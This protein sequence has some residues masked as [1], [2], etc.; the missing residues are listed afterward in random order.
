[1][2]LKNFDGDQKSTYRQGKSFMPSE[3]FTMLIC[4]PRGCGKTN[5][6]FN[7]LLTPLVIYDV[8]YVYAKNLHQHKYQDLQSTFNKM[9]EKTGEQ[10]AHFSSSNINPLSTLEN[11]DLQK[12]AIFD[13]YLEA[14]KEEQRLITEYF[15]Q[16]RHKNCSVIYLSQSYYKTPKDIRLNCTHFCLF[17]FP[18]NR[19]R[20]NIQHDHTMVSMEQYKAATA[21]KFDFLYIDTTENRVAKNFDEEV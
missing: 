9:A 7:I 18:N 10:L 17:A 13:D 1:M 5:A 19:E 21:Q 6:L 16:G 11:D 15:T 2:K 12:L 3:C 4:G 20:Y 14:S 8:L